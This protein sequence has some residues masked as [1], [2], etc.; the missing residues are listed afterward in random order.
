MQLAASQ[1]FIPRPSEQRI[2]T[3]DNFLKSAILLGLF[4]VTLWTTQSLLQR[5]GVPGNGM[6]PLSHA[7]PAAA[8]IVVSAVVAALLIS[9]QGAIAHEGIHK[10][11]SR[12][13]FVNDLVGG[14]LSALVVF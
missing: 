9:A 4:G 2:P 7:I 3:W 11:L 10:V 14:F 6:P 13:R 5:L 1:P 12:N 8:I